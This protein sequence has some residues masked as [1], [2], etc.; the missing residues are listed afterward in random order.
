MTATPRRQQRAPLALVG[1]PHAATDRRPPRRPRPLYDKV[2]EQ[3]REKQQLLSRVRE[4]QQHASAAVRELRSSVLNLSF[5]I[6]RHQDRLAL[7]RSGRF[8]LV[9]AIPSWIRLRILRE[10]L[11]RSRTELSE[12]LDEEQTL[13]AALQRLEEECKHLEMRRAQLDAQLQ[14]QR[15]QAHH[16]APAK[17]H[18]SSRQRH[19][20]PHQP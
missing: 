20:R 8:S 10:Q 19:Q 18:T 13:T 12:L 1:Q 6:H 2:N 9:L 7:L 14:A 11:W 15:R 4:Q 17:A 3:L 16:R 5:Q